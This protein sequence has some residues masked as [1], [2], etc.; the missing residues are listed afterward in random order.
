MPKL[1]RGVADTPGQKRQR[2]ST[3]QVRPATSA[4]RFRVVPTPL[5]RS[6]G[7]GM[8]PDTTSTDANR[9]GTTTPPIVRYTYTVAEAAAILGI[10][11]FSAYECARTGQL[12]VIRLGRRLVVPVTALRTLIEP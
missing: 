10:S 9:L 3:L 12:P 8:K 6:M 11:R 5:F 1:V 4:Q 2:P 7:S